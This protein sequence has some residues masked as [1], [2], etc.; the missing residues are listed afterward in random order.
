[1]IHLPAVRIGNYFEFQ[2]YIGEKHKI[3][4]VNEITQ[5]QVLIDRKWLN[6]NYLIPISITEDILLHSGFTEFNW[7]KSTSVFVCNHFKCTLDSH[8]I[9]LFCENLQNLKS[10]KYLHELQNLY[11]DLTG[12]EL[13]INVGDVQSHRQQIA[14]KV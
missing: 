11:F 8:G 4:R 12:E 13:E 1:M 5:K 14:V 2:P 9:N 6:L 3:G 7:L 10:I